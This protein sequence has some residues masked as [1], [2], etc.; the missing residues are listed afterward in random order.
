MVRDEK[1]RWTPKASNMCDEIRRALIPLYK[2]REDSGLNRED[3]FY[4]ASMALHDMILDDTF[5]FCEF[6]KELNK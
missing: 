4:V 3:F 6:S 5:C 1:N 2:K